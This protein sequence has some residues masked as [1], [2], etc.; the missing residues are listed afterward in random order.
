MPLGKRNATVEK[1][2]K[3]IIKVKGEMVS[4]ISPWDRYSRESMGIED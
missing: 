4:D 1:E 2:I 3:D